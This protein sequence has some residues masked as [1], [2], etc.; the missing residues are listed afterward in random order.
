M[1]V[2]ELLKGKVMLTKGDCLDVLG[3][4]PANFIDAAVTDPPYHLTSNVKRPDE[5]S[6]EDKAEAHAAFNQRGGDPYSRHGR[7]FMG[8][9]W[10]GGD[11]AFRPETWERVYRVLKPG[12]HLLAFAIP[13][14]IGLLQVALQAAGFEFR[15]IIAW[16]FGTGF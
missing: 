4:L 15:D 13:K 14:H 12:G 2:E 9:I 6:E 7:G 8:Q 10:D 1:Q 3:E 11:I 5:S 16:A